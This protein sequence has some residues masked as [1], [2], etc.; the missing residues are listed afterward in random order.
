MLALLCNHPRQ[1]SDAKTGCGEFD[2]E[3]Y[4]TAPAYDGGLETMPSTGIEDDPIQRKSAFKQDERQIS[5]G[6]QIQRA[7][8]CQLVIGRN[9]HSQRFASDLLP[10]KILR[11]G[12]QRARQFD[13]AR[14]NQFLE[15]VAAMLHE[16]D[17]N[18]RI[19]I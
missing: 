17:L 7:A 16:T 19:A 12:K 3:I 6:R 13:L 5:Q 1:E 18:A 9:Q 8:P 14:A 2:D 15:P 11:H 10:L 4:L